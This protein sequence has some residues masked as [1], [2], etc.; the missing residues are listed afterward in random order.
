MILAQINSDY[1]NYIPVRSI[2]VSYVPIVY[3]GRLRNDSF[4]T[5]TSRKTKNQKRCPLQSRARGQL[6]AN[7]YRMAL[8]IILSGEHL[9][10]LLQDYGVHTALAFP[11]TVVV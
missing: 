11:S 7:T 3:R 10:L 9:V 6:G 1:S 8:W 5:P 2:Y 4:S